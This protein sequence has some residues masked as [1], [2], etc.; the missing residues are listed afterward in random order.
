MAI[1]N[2]LNPM[3]CLASSHKIICLV[4]VVIALLLPT[5]IYFGIMYIHILSSLSNYF[6]LK[7]ASQSRLHYRYRRKKNKLYVYGLLYYSNK[8]TFE[9]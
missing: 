7:R 1:S 5:C 8:S 9:T 3:S 4:T 2:L 6:L